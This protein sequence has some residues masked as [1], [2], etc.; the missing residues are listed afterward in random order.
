VGILDKINLRTAP[1][2]RRP[3]AAVEIAPEGVLAAARIESG[4]APAVAFAALS[5]GA[6]VPGIAE[7][8]L[9]QPEAVAAA[10]K[11][12]LDQVAPR[13]RSVSV[14]VPDTSARVF[15][16]DFDSLPSKAA[17]TLPVLRFRLR[18]VVPF[19]VEQAA[20][21]Y[22]VLSEEKH[23][24]KVLAIV[25]PAAI[26][27]EYEGAVRAAGYE[28]GVVLPAGMAAL[29]AL[30]GNEPVLAANLSRGSLTTAITRGNDLLLYRAVELP[31]DP[32]AALE[33]VRR[34][35][36]VAAAYF[37]DRLGAQPERLLY[38]GTAEAHAFAH[39]LTETGTETQLRIE[40]IVSAPATGAMTAMGPVGFAGVFG[41]L[42]GAA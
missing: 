22:Q 14:V 6:V 16:L 8:N 36:A 19:D 41:A 37:E 23:A 25:M 7:P 30:N 5:A 32:D 24:V 35:V 12:A 2:G 38:A 31:A 13:S 10:V 40:E 39:A 33:E 11:S 27:A 42:E 21:S 18:K 20:V 29:A 28:P 4:S 9:R 26:L 17:D 1:S 15:V 3:P 34:S